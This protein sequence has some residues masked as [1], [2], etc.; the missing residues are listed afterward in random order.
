MTNTD[1]ERIERRFKKHMAASKV[2]TRTQVDLPEFHRNEINLGKLLGSGGFS[3][4]YELDGI[5]L[6]TDE[7]GS[8]SS[9]PSPSPPQDNTR[10]GM[11]QRTNT[12][13]RDRTSFAVKHLQPELYKR[14]PREFRQAATDLMVEAHFLA[15]LKHPHIVTMHAWAGGGASAYNSSAGI[16]RADGFFLVLDSLRDTLDNRIGVLWQAQMK[17]YQDPSLRKTGGSLREI[18]FNSR[19]QVATDIASALSY[20]H[21]KNIVYRDLKPS[22]VGFDAAGIVKIFDF[23][24]SREL[25]DK[26]ITN[27]DGSLEDVFAMSGK[28][29]SMRY[30]APEVVLCKPYNQKA[31]VYSFSLVMWEILSIQKPFGTISKRSHREDVIENKQRPQLDAS[32]TFEIRKVLQQSW[33]QSIEERPTMKEIHTA[34]SAN[35]NKLR[36]LRGKS[37]ASLKAAST[38]SKN[39]A[40]ASTK[41][42]YSTSS[43]RARAPR[44]N[45]SNQ[46][47]PL[48]L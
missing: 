19:L 16:T 38:A 17:R 37:D 4:V 21:S 28:V 11:Q 34:L 30:M 45:R 3:H 36:T 1:S 29:G 35:V 39:A 20:L 15:S 23:G 48:L 10:Q 24:L 7:A 43:L 27:R 31:D 22:N 32:W 47:T 25:P 40:A 5:N 14:D 18:F 41:K 33:S 12:L 9:S 46:V 2:L 6:R 8:T 42:S 13:V 44:I 26:K